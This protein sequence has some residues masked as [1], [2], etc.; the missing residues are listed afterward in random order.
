[1]PLFQTPDFND[2]RTTA[3]EAKKALLAKMVSKPTVQAEH[4]VSREQEKA[5]KT[6]AL[7]NAR[8]AE[9][10]AARLAK[11]EAERVAAEALLNNEE[12]QLE[13][14]R[15]ERKDRKAAVKAD[16]RAKRE[17]KAAQRR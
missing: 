7:R 17:M 2:R 6:E 3:L 1:M 10:E 15:Q 4:F 13:L 14:K 11:L 12:A 9:K 16:A 8:A 5:A